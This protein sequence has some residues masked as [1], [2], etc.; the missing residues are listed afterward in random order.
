MNATKA[1]YEGCQVLDPQGRLMF[2]CRRKRAQWYVDRH[3][4]NVV[5]DAPYT[6]KLSFQPKGPGRRGDK[7]HLQTRQNV[8]CVC[9]T[10]EK[11]SRH[12]VV[13]YSYS[14]HMNDGFEHNSHDVLPMCVN[15]HN[16]YE[17]KHS[18]ELRK[19]LATEY[20]APMGGI[21]A[22]NSDHNVIKAAHAIAKYAETIPS[23]RLHMLLSTIAGHIGHTPTIEEIEDLACKRI[24]TKKDK[25]HSHSEIVVSQ[26]TD[27]NKF[28]KMWRQHFL[29]SM[30]PQYMPKYWDVNRPIYEYDKSGRRIPYRL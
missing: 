6:V 14:R 25:Y 10:S 30:T 26:I 5:S 17:E 19:H 7:F 20:N 28:V 8:C 1:I 27:H 4:G 15:C 29:D 2:R 16:E 24:E 11:L 18:Y 9:G 21:E 13:P 12:H 3:L 23:D 22:D